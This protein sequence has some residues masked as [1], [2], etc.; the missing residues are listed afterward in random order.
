MREKS[1]RSKLLNDFGE[2][3]LSIGRF[4]FL[5][6]RLFK[7]LDVVGKGPNRFYAWP[8]ALVHLKECIIV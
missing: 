1:L 7:I 6:K 2:E 4:S 3:N 5:I 8:D